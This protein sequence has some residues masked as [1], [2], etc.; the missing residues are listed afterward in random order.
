VT[1]REVVDIG[2][3]IDADLEGILE[4]QA[5]NQAEKGGRLSANLPRSRIV[6]MMSEMPLIVAR[7]NGRIIGFLMTGTR[8]MNADIPIIRAMLAAFSGTEDAYVYGPICVEGEERGKKIAQA[9][10]AELRRLQPGREGILFI[11]RDNADSLRAHE[12][13]GMHEVA[14]FRFRG[15]EHA[16]LSYFG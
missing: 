11:R 15:V 16:V 14:S 1:E 13:M 7:R 10:F 9:M 8:A 2:Q 3:A 6:A 4:L 12:K 5:A